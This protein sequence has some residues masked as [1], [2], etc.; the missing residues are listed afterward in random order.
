VLVASVAGAFPSGVA[1][2]STKLDEVRAAIDF[3]ADEIDLVIDHQAFLAGKAGAIIEEVAQTKQLCGAR[4]LKVILETGKLGALADVLRASELALVA[5][6]DFLKTSTGK[7]QPAATPAATLVMVEA[8]AR[9]YTASGRKVGIKP[10]GGIRSARQALLYAQ[11]VE[12]TL[13]K[14]WLEPELF[15]LGA[16]ALL[17]DVLARWLLLA[18]RE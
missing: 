17:D 13:G 3:G 7:T 1:A 16:S 12:E 9:H 10:A 18:H 6:A 8:I 2:L 4:R 14:E 15:R 5:G 11:M